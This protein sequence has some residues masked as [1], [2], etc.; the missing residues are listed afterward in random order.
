MDSSFTYLN[1]V[2]EYHRQQKDLYG[3]DIYLFGKAYSLKAEHNL[4]LRYYREALDIST[5]EG[6][7]KDIADV[8]LGIADVFQNKGQSD[9]AI[10]YAKRGLALA[11]ATGLINEQLDH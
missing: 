2:M 3:Y 5:K 4:A 8:C 9:S 1:K 6:I 10:I 7:K 11:N